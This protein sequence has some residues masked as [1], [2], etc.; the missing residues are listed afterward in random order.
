MWIAKSPENNPTNAKKHQPTE[1]QTNTKTEISLEVV[2]RFS[3]L[4]L[5]GGN[6]QLR[7]SVSCQLHHWL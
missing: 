5:P 2:D 1:N 7:P 4:D 3:H 6:R